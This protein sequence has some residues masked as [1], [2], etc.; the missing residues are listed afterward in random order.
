M[1]NPWMKFYPSDWR[2]DPALRM[3]SLGARGLWIEML[4]IMHEAN[5]SLAVNDKQLVPRQLAALAG[6]SVEDVTGWLVE[7][8]D[9]G[10]FSRDADGTIYSRRMR[11]DIAKAE[12]DKANGRK[13]GNPRLKGGVNPPDNPPV[14]GGDK[15]QKPEARSQKPE[16]E[17]EAREGAR[18][19]QEYA[20]EAGVIRLKEIDLARWMKTYSAINVE[21]ALYSLADWAG[22]PE[23]RGKWFG[24]VSGAL[25][26]KDR[27]ARD[28]VSKIQAE[29]LAFANK[30]RRGSGIIP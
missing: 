21:A 28:R 29:A 26:K 25:E 27:E 1:S 23:R 11:K 18:H 15:A 12:E 4:C 5:G 13:G 24:A 6:A 10:V 8:S 19:P 30:P 22:A 14:G 16:R 7:L 20:F 9:A 17:E 3:C 2:A